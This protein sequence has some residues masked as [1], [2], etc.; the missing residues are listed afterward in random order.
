MNDLPEDTPL[1]LGEHLIEL[2]KRVLISL[3]ALL[4]MFVA[5]YLI[6]G[7]TF[8]A[9]TAPLERAFPDETGR[10][11][12]FTG[13]PEAFM[14]KVRLGLFTGFLLA[15]PV[16]AAQVYLFV[17][18]GLYKRE[19]RVVLPYLIAAPLLFAAGL[20]L[21]YFYIFPAAW[22]FFV[23]FET[24]HAGGDGLPVELEARIGEYLS[25]A[26]QIL[27]AFGLA[28][29][30]PI[31][32]TLMARAGLVTSAALAAKRKYAIVGLLTVAAILTPPDVMSQIG[33][34]AALYLLYEI[35][36]ITCRMVSP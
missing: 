21:A 12:I 28:F 36:I 25:L 8:T 9:L 34:F 16:I 20:A 35:S 10:R 29:Q 3:G 18:P 19:K 33:L 22:K 1:S 30:L 5:G 17:A 15:F 24:A 7:E 6:S 14:V 2:K 23:G 27:I 13:L 4:V 11:L 26:M 32:L 31:L